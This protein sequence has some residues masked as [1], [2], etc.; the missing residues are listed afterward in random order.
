MC[1]WNSQRELKNLLNM[2]LNLLLIFGG[3]GERCSS[4]VRMFAHGVMGRRDGPSLWTHRAISCP[5]QCSTTGVTKVGY[6]L[7]CLWDGAFKKNLLLIGKSSPCG[8]SRF[9][10]TELSFTICLTPYK[11]K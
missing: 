5:S 9:L 11:R 7:S 3:L 1:V 10:L 6:L 8:G 2:S 4:V